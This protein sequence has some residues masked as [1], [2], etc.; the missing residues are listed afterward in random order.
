MCLLIGAAALAFW[1]PRW[2]GPSDLRWDGGA[3]YVLG[4]SLARAEGYRILGEPGGL[5]TLS[6]EIRH[7][8]EFAR[9][10]QRHGTMPQCVE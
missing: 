2:G 4:T 1:W 8:L 3:Y 5:S 7:R 9:R 10:P 6:V